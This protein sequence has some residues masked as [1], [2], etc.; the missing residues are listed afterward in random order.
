MEG[1]TTLSQISERQAEA[2]GAIPPQP[3]PAQDRWLHAKNHLLVCR[4]GHPHRIFFV[5]P[6][7]LLSGVS[8]HHAVT[9]AEVLFSGLP[10][11]SGAGS[12]ARKALAQSISQEKIPEKRA[13]LLRKRKLADI[14]STY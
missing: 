3:R 1:A 4:E 8:A 12:E 10:P 2:A 5:R 14:V 7:W 11:R 13:P 6:P 9:P